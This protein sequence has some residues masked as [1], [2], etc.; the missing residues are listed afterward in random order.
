[1][2]REI[3]TDG[4]RSRIVGKQSAALLDDG[5]DR[6]ALDAQGGDR[7]A[8]EALYR[9]LFGNIYRYAL[10][11]LGDHHEAEDVAQ[12]VFLKVQVAIR[13][14]ELGPERRFL[15]WIMRVARNAI[16]D[17]VRQRAKFPVAD[18]FAL[19]EQA[20]EA[21]GEDVLT[22]GWLSNPE[23]A[24]AVKRLPKAQRRV[25]ECR[26]ALGLTTGE[27]AKLLGRSPS[28]IRSQQATALETLERRLRHSDC[29][30]LR[31]RR[32]E[33]LVRT[34]PARVMSRRRFALTGG[35]TPAGALVAASTRRY[36]TAPTL[37]H[38]RW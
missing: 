23:V 20:E 10:A 34:R 31:S 27:T 29:A 37:R 11:N 17:A 3:G 36:A 6:L 32:M 19:A 5:L 16:V 30:R 1:M 35:I 15:P 18:P 33:S 22:L 8:M 7:S 24:T 2:G 9:G 25:I 28:T 21:A 12:E 13:G 26:F 4:D 14:L 38:G